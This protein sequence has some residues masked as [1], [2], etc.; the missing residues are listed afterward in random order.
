MFDL[1][2]DMRSRGA[3]E[4]HHF[5][6]CAKRYAWALAGRGDFAA[7]V[8][9]AVGIEDDIE[10][11]ARA[12][13]RIVKVAAAASEENALRD[14]RNA[15]LALQVR[16]PHAIDDLETAWRCNSWLCSIF[17][18]AGDPARAGALA[19]EVIALG[20]APSETRCLSMATPRTA[21]A[22]NHLKFVVASDPD[23]VEIARIKLLAAHGGP[24]I[25][26]GQI[27]TS[28]LTQR[29]R[30]MLLL[31]VAE[32]D[33]DARLSERY[34]IESLAAAAP[35]GMSA[36]RNHIEQGDSWFARHG[37]GLTKHDLVTEIT[38]LENELAQYRT[39]ASG[40]IQN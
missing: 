24:R 8:R 11:Q 3:F 31:H 26:Y 1:F 19:D 18:H 2:D 30:A 22:K 37:Q 28:D 32:L 17:R 40:R 5:A 23:E 27:N 13:W 12:L 20:L 6:D 16:V 39:L 29:A 25:A 34:F 7:A 14:I 38:R 33:D 36:L 15:A 35:A 21:R 4:S 10:E 9:I